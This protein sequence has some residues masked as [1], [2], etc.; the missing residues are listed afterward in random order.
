MT[1]VDQD[2]VANP[3]PASPQERPRRRYPTSALVG[4]GLGGLVVGAVAGAGASIFLWAFA[5][6][7]QPAPGPLG[8]RGPQMAWHQGPPP[9]PRMFP[10]PM[11]GGPPQLPAPPGG[12][13]FWFGPPPG[14]P[15]PTPA[16]TTP[17]TP[18]R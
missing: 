15:A 14:A 16:P 3:A 11:Q 5:F 17:A 4:V 18:P 2:S 6:G 12:P 9:G 10:G 13:G 8:P 7:P 1:N